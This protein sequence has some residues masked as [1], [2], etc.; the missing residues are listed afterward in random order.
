[1]TVSKPIALAVGNEKSVERVWGE[2]VSGNF[3]EVLRIKPLA[4]RFFSTAEVDGQ[5]NAHPLVII[6][7][8]YWSSHFHS[9]PAAIG[10]TLRINHFPYTVIGVAPPNFRGSMPGLSLSLWTPAT[11]YGQL[12]STGDW[13]LR[14][15]KQR[16]VRA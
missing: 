3:F 10:G 2:V 12:T 5:Q 4:G 9:D 1:M 11:M 7:Q 13:M 16:M 14:D 6:S 15:R 8:A